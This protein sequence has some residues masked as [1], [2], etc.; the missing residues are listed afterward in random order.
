MTSRRPPWPKARPSTKPQA[1]TRKIS[2]FKTKPTATSAD[3]ATHDRQTGSAPMTPPLPQ[4]FEDLRQDSL[5]AIEDLGA[6]RPACDLPAPP[7]ALASLRERLQQNRYRV[8]VVGEAKR[9]KSSFINALIGRPLLPTDVDIATSQVFL[10]NKAAEEDYRVRFEDDTVKE[11]A[12]TELE[13]YGSQVLADQESTPSLD[14]VIRWIEVDVPV[15]FLPDGVS[16]LDTPGLGSLYAAHSLITQRFLPQ[17]DAVIYVLTSSEPLGQRDLETI[18]AI[19]DITPNVL[20]IQTRIDRFAR[21]AWQEVQAR[22]EQVLREELGDK[23]TD[24]RVWPISCTLLMKAAETGDEDYEVLSRHRELAAELKAFLFRVAGLSRVATAI[25]ATGQYHES[26]RQAL[27]TRVADLLSESKEQRVAVQRDMAERKRRFDSD[28]GERGEKR[29]ALIHG[30]RKVVTGGKQQMRQALESGGDIDREWRDKIKALTSL[31]Q[32]QALGERLAEGVTQDAIEKWQQVDQ[33]VR[34]RASEQLVDFETAMEALSRGAAGS[35]LSPE[36]AAAGYQLPIQDD[37]IDK[38][39]GFRQDFMSVGF[40]AG[41]GYCSAG[42]NPDGGAAYFQYLA[43]S[44]CP[45]HSSRDNMSS[46][47]R[48]S[49]RPLSVSRSP[50]AYGRSSRAAKAG[51]GPKSRSSGRPSRSSMPIC[52][53][54]AIRPAATTSTSTS[55]QAACTTSSTRTSTTWPNRSA[56]ACSSLLASARP[57]PSA[58]WNGS[59]NRPSSMRNSAPSG[60]AS[61]APASPSGTPSAS[62][63]SASSSRPSASSRRFPKRPAVRSRTSR[64]EHR[65]QPRHRLWH[66]DQQ[67][68]LGGPA[69]GRGADHQE[70]RGRGEDALGGLLRRRRAGGRHAGRA[71]ARRRRG[72]PAGG[73]ERQAR[74]GQ[75]PDAGPAGPAGQ[76]RRGRRRRARQAQARRRGAALQ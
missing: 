28:W 62:G 72:A 1:N 51:A 10:V 49:R 40:V 61:C 73:G 13:H 41:V 42:T 46:R 2:T 26:A 66:H 68:G 24:P 74:A 14:Q 58:S 27:Q 5:N 44:W 6:E 34:E 60:S 23:L 47:A 7:E 9:G 22:N 12:A 25:L 31:P 64:H 21:E 38:F 36:T 11:I 30:I 48:S 53:A 16:V 50:G 52:T 18:G 29:Q 15:R 39:K 17:A 75:R 67:H 8:L 69:H 20:F 32:A 35:S 55:A 54:C 56:K 43:A 65:A 57:R 4:Q 71:H 33:D 59:N 45:D 70:C 63:S 3:R 19:L 37:W 76:A